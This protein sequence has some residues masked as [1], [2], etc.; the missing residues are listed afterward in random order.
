MKT[1]LFQSPFS[2]IYFDKSNDGTD[3]IWKISAETKASMSEEL[4]N[5]LTKTAPLKF[6][7]FRKAKS[8]VEYKGKLALILEY[9]EGFP[10]EQ[11][12]ANGTFPIAEFLKIAIECTDLLIELEKAQLVH[13]GINLQNILFETSTNKLKLIDFAEAQYLEEKLS[14]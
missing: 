6:E 12:V 3:E 8:L 14:I 2:L 7:G 5:E 4:K 9:V 11:L 1:L 13:R 10:I